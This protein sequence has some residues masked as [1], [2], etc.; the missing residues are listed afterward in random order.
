[1]KGIHD[2]IEREIRGSQ[3]GSVISFQFSNGIGFSGAYGDQI[4]CER[5]TARATSGFSYTT[6]SLEP[7]ECQGVLEGPR[8]DAV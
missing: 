5:F 7:L 2:W 4:V 3:G 1:M 8:A 6:A